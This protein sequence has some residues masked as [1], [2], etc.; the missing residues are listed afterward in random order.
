MANVRTFSDLPLGA[1][2]TST[3]GKKYVLLRDDNH[4]NFLINDKG[5]Y[6]RCSEDSLVFGKNNA[7]IDKAEAYATLPPADAVSESLKKIFTNR[8]ACAALTTVYTRE[9]AEVTAA[10]KALA[11]AKAAADRAAAVIAAY[12]F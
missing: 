7:T 9:P 3:A 10:R 11:D 5:N 12:G 4:Q 2:I 8:P 1:I 6:I